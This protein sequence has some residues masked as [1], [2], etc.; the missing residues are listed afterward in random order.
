MRPRDPDQMCPD[1][2]ELREQLVHG[3]EAILARLRHAAQDDLLQL[4]DDGEV[5]AQLARRH[6][7]LVQMLEDDVHRRRRGERHLAGEHVVQQH[8]Q[9][10]DVAALVRALVARLL[11]RDVVRR[12]HERAR[13]GDVVLRG[14][15][16]GEELHQAE[17]ENLH[18]VVIVLLVQEHHVGGLQIA[19]DDPERVRF[20]QRAADLLRDVDHPVLRQRSVGLHRLRERAAV[21][22]L[23]GDEEDSVVR[24][25]VV[26]ERDGVRVRQLGGDARLEEEPLV[27]VGIAVVPRAQDFKGH[28]AVQR[29]L[30]CLVN[31]AHS[32]VA[33]ALEDPVSIVEDPAEQRIRLCL[34]GRNFRDRA[35]TG[36]LT[37]APGSPLSLARGPPK[38]PARIETVARSSR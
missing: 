11:R 17:V 5:L 8:A 36:H 22:E 12:A 26:V 14:F 29:C 28:H 35:Q 9:R 13:V 20:P 34:R 30:Q 6:R 1:D 24:A 33:N 27:E 16:A 21:E 25:A 38:F 31:T 7:G 10:I 32:A 15:A 4:G 23:H 18:E 2:L 37:S 3:L 19:V